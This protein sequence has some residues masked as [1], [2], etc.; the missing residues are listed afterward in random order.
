M[1]FAYWCLMK[2]WRHIN[3][4]LIQIVSY[5]CSKIHLYVMINIHMKTWNIWLNLVLTLK[6]IYI[7]L[8]YLFLK[9]LTLLRKHQW[10]MG[11]SSSSSSYRPV[12]VYRWRAHSRAVVFHTLHRGQRYTRLC[13]YFINCATLYPLPLPQI[14]EYSILVPLL[15]SSRPYLSASYDSDVVYLA[16]FRSITACSNHR[17]SAC[18]PCFLSA[19]S[20]RSR[21]DRVAI[22]CATVLW[23]RWMYVS[24]GSNPASDISAS[25][26]VYSHFPSSLRHGSFPISIRATWSWKPPGTVPYGG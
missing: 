24:I 21:S 12:S 19:A 17:I 23:P 6:M 15:Y 22:Y 14:Q 7:W 25:A 8:Q 1:S 3:D 18:S 11:L 26:E 9:M 16:P 2:S 13:T 5:Q 10:V 4:M 20:Q